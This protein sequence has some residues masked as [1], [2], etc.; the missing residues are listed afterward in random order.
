MKIQIDTEKKVIKIEDTIK[1][2]DLFDSLEKLFPKDEW[3]EYSLE[4][5]TVINWSSP[6]VWRD[7]ITP[8]WRTRWY[9]NYYEVTCGN[10]T[11]TYNIE[12]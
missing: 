7:Y 1:L 9:P 8:G 3:K 10:T 2:T 4:T 5:G 12:V 6:I 11:G